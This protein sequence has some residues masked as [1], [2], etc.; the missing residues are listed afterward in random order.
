[1]EKGRKQ[2][3]FSLIEILVVLTLLAV[4]GTAGLGVIRWA[5]TAR[6]EAEQSMS[7]LYS[8][9]ARSDRSGVSFSLRVETNEIHPG[10]VAV[11]DRKDAEEERWDAGKGVSLRR[12]ASG[13]GPSR[14]IYSPQWGTFTPALTV[15]VTGSKGDVAYLILSGQG[16]VRVSD[17]PSQS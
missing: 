10:I 12:V 5:P 9:L 7:W 17:Q 11:W 2:P 16:R 3:A 15:K 1:M 8:I 14:I 6:R 4:I 13:G